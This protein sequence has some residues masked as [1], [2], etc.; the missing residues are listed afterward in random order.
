MDR[1]RLTFWFIR[2]AD[3]NWP[4]HDSMER[5]KRKAEKYARANITTAVIYGC[6][7][8]WDYMP[9]FTILHDYLAAVSSEL[10]KYGIEL[11]DHHSVNLVHRYDTPEQMRH[12]MRHSNVHI[13]FSP[14]REMAAAWEYQGKKL[15]SWR[16]TDVRTGNPLLL[17]GKL[18]AA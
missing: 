8:R 6:H 12:V 5:I 7:F 16:M 13:P 2:W 10:A 18:K 17:F 3:L 1:R 15:N 9:Y 4:N 14:S 11:M